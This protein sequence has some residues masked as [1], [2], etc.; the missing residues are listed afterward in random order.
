MGEGPHPPTNLQK[1]PMMIRLDQDLY[2]ESILDEVL[3]ELDQ[4]GVGDCPVR[5]CVSPGVDR[6]FVGVG[7]AGGEPTV[8]TGEL[9]AVDMKWLLL[10][11][12]PFL[13]RVP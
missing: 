12:Y 3:Y 9:A 5:F 7:I 13:P 4:L 2:S 10:V 1:N 6:E 11:D 8:V